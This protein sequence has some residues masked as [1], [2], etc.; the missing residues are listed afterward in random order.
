MA[1]Q[2]NSKRQLKERKSPSRRP[3]TPKKARKS[4][5]A[6]KYAQLQTNVKATQHQ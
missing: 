6:N 4:I 1:S 2:N 5:A 3:Q